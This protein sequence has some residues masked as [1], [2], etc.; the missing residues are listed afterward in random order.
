VERGCFIRAHKPHDQLRDV[1]NRFG[2]AGRISPFTRCM[3]CNGQLLAVTKS[4]VEPELPPH[5]KQTK[6]EFKRCTRCGKVYWKGSHHAA[7]LRRIES[8]SVCT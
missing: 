1:L 4:E 8:L 7:M 3:Y 2:L 5:T 6:N